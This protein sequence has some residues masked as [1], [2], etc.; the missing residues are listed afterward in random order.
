MP[1]RIAESQLCHIAARQGMPTLTLSYNGDPVASSALENFAFEVHSRHGQ[2]RKQ[3]EGLKRK[4]SG[5]FN[6]WHSMS[7]RKWHP[8][9]EL[10]LPI[11][12]IKQTARNPPEGMHDFNMAKKRRKG[13]IEFRS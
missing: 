13:N 11:W 6:R 12:L 8:L 3:R 1:T 10:E 7:S 4:T 5:L 9:G 2:G